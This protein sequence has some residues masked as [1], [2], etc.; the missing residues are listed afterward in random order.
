MEAPAQGLGKVGGFLLPHV[1]A[2]GRGAPLGR[3]NVQVLPPLP[4]V[5]CTSWSEAQG[6]SQRLRGRVRVNFDNGTIRKRR[7]ASVQP[8]LL[9]GLRKGRSA[10]EQPCLL[11]GQICTIINGHV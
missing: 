9:I 10:S 11:I 8:C 7:S 3:E 4:L 1:W 2:D 5:V 6:R